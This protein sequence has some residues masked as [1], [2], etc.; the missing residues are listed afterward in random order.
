MLHLLKSPPLPELDR[1]DLWST[2]IR[3]CLR[4]AL[5]LGLLLWFS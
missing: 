2:V 3:P 4:L 5:S 1:H